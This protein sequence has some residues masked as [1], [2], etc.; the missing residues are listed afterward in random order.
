M[1]LDTFFAYLG[2]YSD[3]EDALADYA[4]VKELHTEADLIDA[5]GAWADT[6]AAMAGALPLGIQPMRRSAAILPAPDGHDVDRWPLFASA[7]RP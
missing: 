7:G 5:A 3:P 1:P 2:T 4:A 6:V